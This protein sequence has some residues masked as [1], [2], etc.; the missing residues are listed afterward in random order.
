[1]KKISY[2]VGVILLF[3]LSTPIKAD[4]LIKESATQEQE[5]NYLESTQEFNR[6]NWVEVS[7]GNYTMQLIFDFTQPIYFKK[8]IIPDNLQLR[9]SFP[10]MRL[11]HFD[12]KQVLAKLS[13]LK[14]LG[15][16]NKIDLFEKSQKFPKVVLTIDFEKTRKITNP[17]NTITTIKNS[18]LI[19][20]CKMEE[21]N[22]LVFDIFTQETLSNLNAK[23]SIILQANN[24][25]I[26]SDTQNQLAS[27]FSTPKEIGP[28]RIVLDPGHGGVDL[29]AQ[30][31]GLKEKD[32][33][34]DI[35]L[36]TRSLLKKEGFSVLLTRNEDKEISLSERTELAHQLKA[37]LFVSI[38]INSG[39]A[40]GRTPSGLETYYLNTKKLLPPTRTGGFLFVN[41]EK[42]M[43]Y[44]TSIDNQ[45]QKKTNLSHQLAN[46]IQNN[47]I[48]LLR[49][50]NIPIVN[51]GVKS[52]HFRIFF[53]SPSPTALVE[54]GFITNKKE[55][56][57]LAS[58]NY[59]KLL[60]QGICKG[61]TEYLSSYN[62]AN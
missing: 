10:G 9:I 33:A 51:R 43:D 44:A 60:A 28:M 34:L 39:G 36:R 45:L 18:L 5:K 1:M 2:A 13:K 16:V 47:I 21:P 61:I 26:K 59:R 42:N 41:L 30:S 50:Q 38:H 40:A 14:K 32:L 56:H 46:T 8:K 49:S 48:S 29:G 7:Q 17:D 20:W 15:F 24:D 58:T 27:L 3:S 62:E 53:N 57:L 31:Y 4:E 6:L 11:Q 23:S 19:K 52:E 55:A 12:K 35:A 22:R 37:Q 25:T 54:V